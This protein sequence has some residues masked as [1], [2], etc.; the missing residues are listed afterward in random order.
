M[1]KKLKLIF[2]CSR[3]RSGSTVL[4]AMLSTAQQLVGVGEILENRRYL[5]GTRRYPIND[6]CNCG[7]AIEKCVFWGNGFLNS[8]AGKSVE[9]TYLAVIE[10]FVR[11]Y[12]DKHLVDNSKYIEQ[13]APCISALS[14]IVDLKVLFLVRDFRGWIPSIQQRRKGEKSYGGVRYHYVRMAY[15]WKRRN[16]DMERLIQ[17]Q[18]LDYLLVLYD[19][20]LLDPE[21]QIHR[22]EQFLQLESNTIS[23]DLST[24][25]FHE[26]TGSDTM[27]ERIRSNPIVS[28]D[29]RWMADTAP[30]LWGPLMGPVLQY[31]KQLWLRSK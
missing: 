17:D 9:A 14:D 10:H 31:N 19:R 18:Q 13:F 24:S 3:A 5:H 12:P 2:I 25:F 1:A 7:N 27:P 29:F 4:Q 15:Q 26:L 16:R 22:I 20:L 23:Q 21:Q 28:Y 11:Q 8:M 6:V 30:F